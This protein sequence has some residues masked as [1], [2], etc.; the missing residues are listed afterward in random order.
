MKKYLYSLLF[1]FFLPIFSANA[2]VCTSLSDGNWSDPTIWSCGRVPVSNADIVIIDHDVVLDQD[3]ILTFSTGSVLHSLTINAGASLIDNGMHTLQIGQGSGTG[4][5]GINV[6]GLLDVYI[7]TL[8]KTISPTSVI[9]ST[10]EII[11][12]CYFENTNRGDID[13]NGFFDIRG[14]W[15][16]GNGNTDT[17]GGGFVLVEGCL[18][19]GGGGNLDN[20]TVDY[21]VIA[22]APDC[23]CYNGG[24][25]S[26]AVGNPNGTGGNGQG[27]T[28]GGR[29]ECLGILP[30]TY[31]SFTGKVEEATQISNAKVTLQWTTVSELNHE[32][33]V[34]ERSHEGKPF[35]ALG[36]L[37]AKGGK[38]TL[39]SYQFI[40]EDT[41]FGT[42]YY[43]LKEITPSGEVSYSPV[44]S[45][46]VDNELFFKVFPNPVSQGQELHVFYPN[47]IK[48]LLIQNS[49]GQV[50]FEAEQD[51]KTYSE[52]DIPID[53]PKGLYFI[54]IYTEERVIY[55]RLIVE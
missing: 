44:V 2:L 8:E 30:V 9:S 43:R 45:I 23:L 50:I 11:V 24:N 5:N 38:N 3:V 10:G 29:D 36:S 42:S 16:I 22:P 4:Y 31:L 26:G 32:E 17:S 14:D 13:V 53:L 46:N 25:D 37:K 12:R 15:H 48:S 27:T 35:K 6:E 47:A 1:L 20:I 52:L 51:N 19:T 55:R 40:D 41:E 34:V 33:F 49:Q 21:C 7:L 54:Q 39:T 28:G 18:N